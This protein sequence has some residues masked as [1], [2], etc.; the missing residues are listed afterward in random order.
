MKWMGRVLTLLVA[1]VLSATFAQAQ[2]APLNLKVDVPF[3]FTVGG[4][5]F[6]SGNYWIAR[7]APYTLVLRD[8]RQH[9]LATVFTVPV[10]A[11]SS[12]SEPSVKFVTLEGRHLLAEVWAQGSRNGFQVPGGFSASALAKRG[13][14][15]T[16]IANDARASAH[17]R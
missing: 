16:Q 1:G 14:A 7:T 12:H 6:P 11:N 2:F 13:P 8:A 15:R 10:Q 4:R 3:E 9:F 17:G 5:T